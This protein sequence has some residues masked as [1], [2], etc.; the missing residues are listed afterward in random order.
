M[1]SPASSANPFARQRPPSGLARR[2]PVLTL[3][4]S[5]RRSWLAKDVLAGLV[6]TAVLVPVGMGYAQAAGLPPL[7]GLYATVVP[8]IVY[9]MLGPSRILVLGPDSALAGLI[10][11]AVLP[12]AA[13]DTERTVALAGMLAIL[14]GGLCILAG[15]ARF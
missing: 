14:T 3:V 11:A 1:T 15:V 8:L 7:Y 13:A 4:R 2:L 10:A 9:A 5:Y 6:L 12:L